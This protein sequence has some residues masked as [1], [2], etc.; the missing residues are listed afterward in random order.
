MVAGWSRR[1]VA[2]KSDEGGNTMKAELTPPNFPR[3]LRA[4]RKRL[5]RNQPPLHPG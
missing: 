3:K 1:L 2:P 5:L 4:G